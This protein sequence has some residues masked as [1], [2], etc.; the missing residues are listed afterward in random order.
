MKK[1][2][3]LF[4][5]TCFCISLLAQKDTVAHRIILMGD[6]GEITNNYHPVSEAIKKIMPS[7][8][9]STLLILGDNIYKKGLPEKNAEGYA[10]AKSIIDAQLSIADNLKA[11]VFVIPGNHD[12]NGGKSG[13]WEAIKRQQ[14]YVDSYK[15]ENVK[16]YPKDGCPGPVEISISN[17]ITLLLFDSQWWLHKSDKPGEG[18]ACSCKSKEEL[19]KQ[20]GEIVTRNKNKLLIIASHHPFRSHG[21]HGG[22]YTIKQHI[23]PFTDIRKWAW[24]PL[25][26]IGSIYPL[27]RA[28]FGTSQDLKNKNYR[29]MVNGIEAVIGSD[30]NV[31]FVAGHEHGLQ[32]N[33]DKDHNYVVSGGASKATRVNTKKTKFGSPS[34]G[35]AVLEVSTNK[36]V[37]VK[38]Y[39][40]KEGTS[41]V[42]NES[43]L[44]Y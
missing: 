42:Y 1:I 9:K 36:T 15:N 22:Y 17:D 34:T 6:G 32:L 29:A 4:L 41:L 14:Q 25:P 18:S 26:V 24:L 20:I 3:G 8:D 37:T 5:V 40:V 33:Q 38:F 21:P 16:F 27:V 7:D 19:I 12:W 44:R 10:H 43:L 35:F 39:T 11:K 28:G 13:G 30:P 31:I 2:I 23:F